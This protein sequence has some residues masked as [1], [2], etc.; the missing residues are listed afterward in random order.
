MAGEP[1]IRVSVEFRWKSLG[2]VERDGRGDLVFPAPPRGPGL[3]RFRLC[4]EGVEKHYVGESEELRRRFQQYR[5]PGPSQRT[6][7]RMNDDCQR[8]LLSGGRV[9]VDIATDEMAISLGDVPFRV[10]L[11]DKVTRS[12]LEQ[13]AL[14]SAM[15]SGT[16]MLNR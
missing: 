10:D 3:Y 8:H 1:A 5:K 4:G 6:N 11:A 2:R 12:L 7:L 14:V 13:A 16:E 15:A 9:E